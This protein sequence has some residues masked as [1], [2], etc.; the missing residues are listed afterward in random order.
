[1]FGSDRATCDIWCGE[2]DEIYNIGR[3]TFSITLNEQMEVILKHHKNTNRTVVQ[4]GT[5]RPK[6]RGEMVWIMLTRSDR[7]TVTSANMLEF[8]VILQKPGPQTELCR[9]LRAQFLK[10]VECSMPSMPLLALDS[11]PSTANTSVVSTPNTRPF[12][13]RCKDQVLGRGSF[14]EVT[15]VIDVSTGKEYAGKTFFGTFDRREV[16]ILARQKD[17][18]ILGYV[19][20]TNDDGPL[21]VTEYLKGGNLARPWQVRDQPAWETL[22]VL[23]VLYQCLY[24]LDSLHAAPHPV[25]HRDIKPQNILVA[26]DEPRPRIKLA[27]FGLAKEGTKCRG[28][29]GT[30][31]YTAP[32]V[33]FNMDCTSKLDVWSVGVVILQLLLKGRIPKPTTVYVQGPQWCRDIVNLTVVNFKASLRQDKLTLPKNKCTLKTLLWAFIGNFM[34]KPDPR[35]RLSARECLDHPAFWEMIHMSMETN[36]AVEGNSRMEQQSR[37]SS[38]RSN[39]YPSKVDMRNVFKEEG[40]GSFFDSLGGLQ[41]ISPEPILTSPSTWASVHEDNKSPAAYDLGVEVAQVLKDSEESRTLMPGPPSRQGNPQPSTL[42]P[43]PLGFGLVF[44][45]N[46]NNTA[47]ASTATTTAS[48]NRGGP[49]LNMDLA[50]QYQHAHWA[51]LKVWIK[52]VG[53]F[54]CR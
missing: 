24:G 28:Q 30:F 4:Y 17:H 42:D 6:P 20:L 16:D 48:S 44:E 14:G 18:F 22:Q 9:S 2:Y 41:N 21:L 10:D 36:V 34:L 29:A 46:Q 19:D 15:V 45:G 50:Q 51:E 23:S 37:G 27:D 47:A 7:I 11:G 33:F 53:E 13:Y 25:I 3:Q 35:K 38:S 32:E 54:P 49:V 8:E 39:A 43:Q 52:S 12:Y 26:D 5:Q 40:L 1:M 31:L